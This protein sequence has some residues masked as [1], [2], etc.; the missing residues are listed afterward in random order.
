VDTRATER[1]LN[2]M[3][4]KLEERRGPAGHSQEDT[5]ILDAIVNFHREDTATFAIPAHKSGR[6]AP[7]YAKEVLGEQVF[8]ADQTM[9]NGVDNRHESWEIQT[10]AQNLAAEAMGADQCLFSTNGSTTSVHAAMT[11]V[12][13]PGDKLAVSRNSHKSVITGLIHTGA[14]PVWLEPEYDEDLEVAHGIVSDTLE[15]ALTEHPDC[16][17]VFL[18]TPSYYGVCSDVP[19][20]AEISHQRGLP[21][22]CD[23]AWAL[24]YKFHPELP[25]FALDVGA[26][27]A[28]GSCHKTLS[29]LSQTSIISVKGSRIDSNRLSL[30]LETHQSTSGSAVL[31]ASIDAARRQMVQE[32][33]ELIGE[34]LRLARWLR[35]EVAELGLGTI[36]PLEILTRVSAWH[37]NELHV[38]IDVQSLGMTGYKAS[39]WLRGHHGVAVELADHRRVMAAVS[40]ADSN[41]SIGRL[42]AAL[43]DMVSHFGS[44]VNLTRAGRPIP[45]PAE[46]RTEQVISPRDAFYA[47]T[48]MVPLK[49][50]PGR[51]AAEFVTPYP[52]G[53]P[54][55]APGE[56]ITEE[57]VDYLL[58][59]A[60][61]GI[62][63]EGCA[64][65]S[66]G[67]AR[68]VT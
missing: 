28:I 4:A 34:A 37:F 22:I 57:I 62:Y 7:A 65:Q 33:E 48:E 60:A 40:H 29:G 68:V 43:K 5:P 63:V 45:G 53:I 59:G 11:A 19:R 18:V 55:V 13:G 50:A 58:T 14:M 21:L 61:E 51:L 52:P 6:G 23:D 41:E 1:R 26:D 30:A 31:L 42:L 20:L 10:A 38:T 9:L 49:E 24:A 46:L 44:G 17:A 47:Q 36:E 8:L 66:L 67:S 3:R 12:V 27:L 16:R 35:S 2:Q 54:L 25:P 15:R 64:D 39:D 56:R 32:G